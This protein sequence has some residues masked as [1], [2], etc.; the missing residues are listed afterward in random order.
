MNK[1]QCFKP[2]LQYFH[3]PGFRVFFIDKT[4]GL[5]WAKVNLPED[6]IMLLSCGTCTDTR[7]Q[8]K[9]NTFA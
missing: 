2:L 8:L 7:F 4:I 3:I 5:I 6:G 9:I 1:T